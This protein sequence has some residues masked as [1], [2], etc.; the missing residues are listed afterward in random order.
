MPFGAAFMP[1]SIQSFSMAVSA[2]AVALA[3]APVA[4]AERPPTPKEGAT[5]TERAP[6]PKEGARPNGRGQAE[7]EMSPDAQLARA[8][9]YY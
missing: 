4:R 2:L 8:A 5:R 9:A 1:G 6:T 3:I 7:G